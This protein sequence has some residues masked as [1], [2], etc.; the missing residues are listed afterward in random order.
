MRFSRMWDI[1]GCRCILDSDKHVYQLKKLLERK[2]IIKKENDYIKEPQADGYRSLHL[3]VTLP[4]DSTVI[5]LQL[6]NNDDHN[7]ATL[8]EITDLLFETKIKEYKDHTE[9]SRFHYLLSIIEDTTLHEKKEIIRIISKHKY[10]ERLSE[11]FARNYLEVRKQWLGIQNKTAHKYFLIESNKDDVPSI[12]SYKNFIDAELDYF[13]LYK[14]RPDANAVLTHLPFPSYNHIS[15]AYSNYI[16]TFH[17]FLRDCDK[18]YEL[19]ILESLKH[20]RIIDFRKFL[21]LYSEMAFNRVKTLTEETKIINSIIKSGRNAKLKAK[22]KEWANDLQATIKSL[23]ADAASFRK[24]FNVLIPTSGIKGFV[25]KMILKNNNE[26]Y[27]E[28]LNK[29]SR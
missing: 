20:Q 7:W 8:V 1:G 18:L 11:V 5:E 28:R 19:L 15:I 3:Y 6:R 27:K 26:K 10:L 21:H 2:L 23:N 14:N 22:E 12:E 13:N 17:A 25:F 16:L 4:G 29:L 24:E 9:L